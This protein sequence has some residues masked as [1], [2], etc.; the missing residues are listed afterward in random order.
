M[1][2]E[3]ANLSN[4]KGQNYSR[5]LYL[6]GAKS[7]YIK[8]RAKALWSNLRQIVRLFEVAKAC[9]ILELS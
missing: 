6:E 4:E 5:K 9:D 8:F 7:D 2:M 1:L 3:R